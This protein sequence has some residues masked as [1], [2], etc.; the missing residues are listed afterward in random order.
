MKA[1]ILRLLNVLQVPPEKIVA[2]RSHA[3]KPKPIYYQTVT[4]RAVAFAFPGG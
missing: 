3:F 2:V 1:D 4:G